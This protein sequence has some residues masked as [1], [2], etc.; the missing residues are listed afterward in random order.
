MKQKNQRLTWLVII[1]IV[2]MTTAFIYL[3]LRLASVTSKLTENTDALAEGLH[4][5]SSTLNQLTS[6]FLTLAADTNEVRSTL[7]LPQH[8][9][10]FSSEDTESPEENNLAFFNGV[11]TI[12]SNIDRNRSLA[13]FNSFIRKEEFLN[14]LEET[15]LQI[16]SKEDDFLVLTQND[17]DYFYLRASNDKMVVV[18]SYTGAKIETS[19]EYNELKGFLNMHT[20]HV[21]D[22][23]RTHDKIVAEIESLLE[24]P[25]VDTILQENALMKVFPERDG[26]GSSGEIQTR[27]GRIL[28]RFGVSNKTNEIRVAGTRV[29][30]IAAFKEMLLDILSSA[31][32]RTYEEIKIDQS[33]ER[34][35]QL[36]ED[37]GFMSYLDSEN[38]TLVETPREDNDY[39]YFDLVDEG[40]SRLGSFAVQKMIGEIYLM[41]E[42][43]VPISSLKTGT[44]TAMD[45]KKKLIIPKNLES[46]LSSV[47]SE[48]SVTILIAGAHE[49][50]ADTLILANADTT[51]G[52]ITLISVPRDLFYR[53]RKI[54]SLYRIFGPEYLVKTLSDIT[55][56][57]IEDYVVIDMYAFIDVINILGGIDIHLEESLIDP[58]YRVK[59]N[60]HWG[61]LYYEKGTHHLNGIE[62]LRVARSRHYSS[63]FGRAERQQQIIWAIK[64]KFDSLGIQDMG[65][66]YDLVQ[67]LFDYVDTS[68]TPFESISLLK[69]FGSIHDRR[70]YVLNTDNILYDSYTNVFFVEDK[71]ICEQE[72]YD[73]G[74]W[75]LL[76][77]DNDWDVIPWYVGTILTG[78]VSE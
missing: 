57:L 44:V 10:S 76:P 42:D 67:A 30:D 78:E 5:N 48:T 3:G 61:T 19:G 38:L 15:S 50:N 32:K 11:D 14:L 23:Y 46:P 7:L 73:K 35:T 71:S 6:A 34:I 20:G 40:G 58:T 25:E 24:S 28:V 12:V 8:T 41:D 74:A 37:S 59:D 9:Y 29:S 33:K 64:D 52:Q 55:G 70:S 75:I 51:T 18:E 22:L 45:S 16:G 60:G 56:L 49:N 17:K 36:R 62:S 13:Y 72:G 69:N 31:D 65:K 39:Y 27:D 47:A 1:A 2:I 63:D 53:G 66:L 26:E 21:I 43:D 54:N 68:L 4:E 77:V